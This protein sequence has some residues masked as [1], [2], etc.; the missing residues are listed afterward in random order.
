MT[1][2]KSLLAD[3]VPTKGPSVTFGDN[4]KGR[5]KGYG[6]LSNGSITFNKVAYVKGLMHNLLSISQLCDLGYKVMFE[7]SSCIIFNEKM[8]TV[9]SGYRKENVYV[10]DMG[11]SSSFGTNICFVSENSAKRCWLWHKRLSHLNFKTLNVLSN[12]ELVTGMPK[13][14][15]VKEKLCVACEKGKLTKSS[16]KS[17]QCFSITQPLQMLHMDMCGPVSTPSL[18][19]RRYILVIID[20]F[21]RYTWVFFLRYKSDTTKEII[22]FI[23]KSEVLNGQLVRSVRSD[24]GTE[25]KNSMLDDFFNEKGISQNFS[26]VRTPQQNDVVERKN[27]T[28][29]EA[30]RSMLSESHLPTYFW[31]EA[32]NTACFTQNRSIIVK[33]HNKTPYEVFYGRKPNIGFLHVFGC[34]CY[35]LNDRENLGKFDPKA[36]EGIFVG[37]SLTSKAFRVYNLRRKCIDE[38][39]HVK[40][41]DLKISS[42]SCDD[43][44]LNRWMS[45]CVDDGPLPTSSDI[46]YTIPTSLYQNNEP[47]T[48]HHPS[49]HQEDDPQPTQPQHTLQIIPVSPSD[50][51]SSPIQADLPSTPYPSNSP[52]QISYPPPLPPALKWTKDHP[53][54]QIIGDQQAGVQTRRGAGN[55][56]L[57]VNFLS[58]FEPKKVDEALADP[59]WIT[60]MQEE[61]SQFERNKVWRLVPRPS[62]KTIIGT[63]WVFRN[64][65]DEEG[66]VIRNKARLVAQGYRQEEGID[67]DETFAPVAR[68]E[69]IRIFLAHAAYKNFRVFQMDVKSAFLNGELAEEVY[70]K[71]PPG[72]EDP[73]H[74]DYVYRLDKALY[75]LKQ[76]PRAWYD[77]LA[78]FLLKNKYTRGKIDNTLFI[79][80]TSG[81]L[82]LVQIYVDDIIFGATDESLCDEF[83]SLMKSQYEMSM[84]GELTFFLGLQVKQSSEGIFINQSKYIRDLLKK[85][86][87]E[88]S[89]PMKTPMAP[90]LK[91][92]ADPDGVSVDITSYRGMIGS[93][94]YLTASRPDI[95]FATCL[96]AR[97]QVNPKES[98]LAAVKRIFRYLKGTMNLG[99]WYP[100]DSG[101]DLM[102][103]SDSDFAGSKIDRKSTTGSCQL[104]GGKLVS[105]S[106]KKQNSVSTSTAE[107]EYVAAGSCCAQVLWMKNQL[108]DYN[109]LYSH[110]PILCDNSSAIAIANNPV[111]HSRS[112]HIDIRYH[113]I[114]DHISKGDVELH[115]IPTDLQLADLFTKPLDEARFKFL[116]GELGM[117]N[118]DF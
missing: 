45:S 106:S 111:L 105:W 14:S 18:G 27:R 65:M 38:S 51:H 12:Q 10:I 5:T 117:L 28:L 93:L 69:A 113:F 19:G 60:A 73:V 98:H 72:F 61:L 30:A 49:S 96:C 114:R 29:C 84:M 76:A 36:D 86:N 11:H 99:L 23:K 1:G 92:H 46:P 54:D 15:F 94:L 16:F 103:Y 66:T 40:F 63:K 91:L 90:P 82:I 25:F 50:I 13:L 74:P 118:A 59:C 110:I 8:E 116:I 7:L 35:I 6:T 9:L 104:L 70:V 21:T 109:Q 115:F 97:Y 57:Y 83:A 44:E 81:N 43:E 2:N 67:Y 77:T 41:D 68:L 100:K 64:K 75:G 53:I 48:S 79:K 52:L 95:M 88:N 102:G 55:I 17:K 33:R 3:F 34:V 22:N 26:A 39:I 78:D 112:K 24:N 4:S 62:R 85:F 108:R 58:L 32:I 31:A 37:Y 42:L 47:S 101:F 89:S 20:E 56:C 107:A 80:Q 71:Q 87:F